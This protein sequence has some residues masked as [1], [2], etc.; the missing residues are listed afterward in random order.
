[1]WLEVQLSRLVPS[2]SW[3][4]SASSSLW[5]A[6]YSVSGALF[7]FWTGEF[8]RFYDPKT[9]FDIDGVWIDMNEPSSVCI[10]QFLHRRLNSNACVLS[11]SS[12]SILARMLP[13][14]P[15]HRASL[16][17][18]THCPPTQMPRYLA[19][20]VLRMQSEPRQAMRARTC[21]IP[22]TP[23]IMHKVACLTGL[24]L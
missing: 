22:R 6:W 9:G 18:A 1:V 12:V 16:L 24:H 10:P 7:R 21:S 4:V 2:E 17:R 20:R 23:L 11:Y 14:R 19:T 8:E 3:P 13:H 5:G 15:L